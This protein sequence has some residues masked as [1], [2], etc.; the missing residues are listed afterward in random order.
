M[1]A[2]EVRTLA[3]DEALLISANRQP[4]K[5]RTKGYFE[6]GR[7]RSITNRSPAQIVKKTLKPIRYTGI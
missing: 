5:M 7:L 1:N 6:I 4:V 2:D 3:D